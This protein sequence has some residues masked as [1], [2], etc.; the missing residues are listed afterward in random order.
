MDF[1]NPEDILEVKAVKVLIYG[2]PGVRKSTYAMSAAN[3]VVFDWDKGIRRVSA[4]YRSKYAVPKDWVDAVTTLSNVD[5]SNFKTIVTDTIGASLDVLTE[6]IKK[7]LGLKQA[8]GSLTTKGYGALK[9]IW[10]Q[11]YFNSLESLEMD[12]VFVAHQSEERVT[13]GKEETVFL[14]P[15]I[16]GGTL[17]EV[18]KTMD[19]VGYMDYVQGRPTI[20]FSPKDGVFFAKNSAK[21]PDL[22]FIDE[23]SLA[24]V[25]E[26][27]KQAVNEDSTTYQAYQ[28]QMNTIYTLLDT[29]TDAKTL[30]NLV[31]HC[32]S[33]TESKGWI[34]SANVE[35]K[36]LI[37]EKG[38]EL[39]LDREKNGFYKEPVEEQAP[40]EQA[41]EVTE[42]ET[43]ENNTSEPDAEY[44]V[45]YVAEA[46]K[47][48][49]K[50]AKRGTKTTPNL[51]QDAAK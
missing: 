15:D 49:A 22:I 7:T 42:P 6:H 4:K 10:K 29:A 45:A 8:D 2:A 37:K 46:P 1:H 28:E 33:I 13:K 44:Q 31:R 48:E 30:N 11:G 43:A 24:Q 41:N 23:M 25:I 18:L 32:V 17:K 40:E 3:P 12:L 19:L 20:S 27:F 38:V 5:F 39:G 51:K 9:S 35:A 50:P 26:R 47:E 34:Y 16:V 21:L 14:R 36:E